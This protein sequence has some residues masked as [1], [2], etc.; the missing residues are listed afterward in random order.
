MRIVKPDICDRMPWLNGGGETIELAIS[1]HGANFSSFG[2]RLSAARVAKDGPFSYLSGIDR[3]LVVTS[4]HGLIVKTPDA[5]SMT[6][7]LGDRPWEFPGELAVEASLVDGPV[8]D[9]NVMTRRG[10]FAH[11]MQIKHALREIEVANQT[12]VSI[13]SLPDCKAIIETAD[14]CGTL[15]RGDFLIL[16]ECARLRIRPEVESR[17]YQIRIWPV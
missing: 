11:K 17:L 10:Q 8:E 9:L 14:G 5:C 13:F 16:E 15:D 4:G 7:A 2:W 6:L 3:T 12:G 1:P